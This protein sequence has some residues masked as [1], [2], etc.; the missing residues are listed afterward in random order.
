MKKILLI[1]LVMFL[2]MSSAEARK[3]VGLSWDRETLIINEGEETCIDYG[4]YNPWDEDVNAQL[5]LSPELSAIATEVDSEIKYVVAQ[6]WHN[7]SIP[8]RL[9]FKVDN[10]Y[11]KD[12][13]I[14]NQV[15]AQT[16]S[17]PEKAYEGSVGA[18]EIKDVTGTGGTGSATNLAVS[19]P[20]KL[21]VRCAPHTREY[22]LL[23]LIILVAAAIGFIITLWYKKRKP[24]IERKKELL[25][26]LKKEIGEDQARKSEH[27]EK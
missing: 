22:I 13:L 9:C 14:G 3:G 21:R 27:E 20:L 2:A 16:C 23:W 19:V 18:Q 4:I 25:E 6:T 10:V 1:A 15:C 17:V 11:E 12:C 8:I 5:T 24:P 7:K 26:K